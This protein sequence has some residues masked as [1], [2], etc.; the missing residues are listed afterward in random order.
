MYKPIGETNSHAATHQGTC[1]S[2]MYFFFFFLNRGDT[3]GTLKKMVFEVCV[4]VVYKFM[5]GLTVDLR[6][7]VV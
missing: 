4:C 5:S 7:F 1:P 3:E 2:L 6:E